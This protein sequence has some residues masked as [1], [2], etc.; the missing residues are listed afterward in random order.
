MTYP[1][2]SLLDIQEG[3]HNTGGCFSKGGNLIAKVLLHRFK[4]VL[5]GLGLLS[6]WVITGFRR[7]GAVGLSARIGVLIWK[8]VPPVASD[9]LTSVMPL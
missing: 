8:P 7:E 3:M 6:S 1:T 2:I 5:K 4:D 9:S